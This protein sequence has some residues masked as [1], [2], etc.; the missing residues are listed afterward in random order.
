MGY[1]EDKIINCVNYSFSLFLFVIKLNLLCK[2]IFTGIFAT[3]T[4]FVIKV[5]T[6]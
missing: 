1:G 5:A 3:V 2:H 4:L 6:V